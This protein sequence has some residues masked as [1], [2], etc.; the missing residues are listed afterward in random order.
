MADVE[1]KKRRTDLLQVHSPQW[2]QLDQLLGMS[3]Q[4]LTQLCSTRRQLQNRKRLSR[5][6]SS[7]RKQQRKTKKEALPTKKPKVK[8]HLRSL[9]ILPDVV[10]S[11]VGIYNGNAFNQ[12][13]I[14]R[15]MISH[16]LGKFIT[17]KASI[18]TTHSSS[19]IPLK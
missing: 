6:P 4:Q 12:V 16:Y 19:F 3:Y 5:K 9:L 1:Q 7:L 15:E 10:G 17:Y 13:E 11:M 18:G 2:H 14:N 8:I